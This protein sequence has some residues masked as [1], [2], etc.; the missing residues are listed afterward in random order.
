VT[1]VL[2]GDR[3]PSANSTKCPNSEVIR[4]LLTVPLATPKS[5]GHPCVVD[6]AQKSQETASSTLE[7]RRDLGH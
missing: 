6:A 3:S 1:Y 7:G 2:L 5:Q 4:R